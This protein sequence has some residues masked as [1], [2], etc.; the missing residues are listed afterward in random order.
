MQSPAIADTQERLL[1]CLDRSSGSPVWQKAVLTAPLERKNSLNSFA[2]STPATD[3]GLVYAAFLDR[4]TMFVAAYDFGRR[5]RWVVH[6]GPF[7]SMHGVCSSPLLY[8]DTV[9]R[10]YFLNDKGVM[11]VVKPG[12]RFERVAQDG[13]GEKCFASPAIGNGQILLRGERHLFCIGSK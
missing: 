2:S 6:P 13:I 1:L 11:N 5:R 10:V 9:I 3:G 7:A 4:D 12:P 8:G